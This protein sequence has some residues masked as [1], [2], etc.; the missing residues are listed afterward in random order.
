MTLTDAELEKMAEE[1]V[2]FVCNSDAHSPS[3]VG[4][5]SA[6]VAAIER[7]HIPYSLI[8]N[9]ERFPS[10]RSHNYRRASGRGTENADA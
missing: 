4:D 5:M 2:E 10:F 9:W 6:A 1:G 3:R 8:A 7:L